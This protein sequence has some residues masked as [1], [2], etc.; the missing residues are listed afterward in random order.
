MVLGTVGE[1]KITDWTS[2]LTEITWLTKYLE[3]LQL[4]WYIMRLFYFICLY[5]KGLMWTY[6]NIAYNDIVIPHLDY[7]NY[8][9]G[10]GGTSPNLW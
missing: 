8:L 5:R 2:K 9:V 10:G 6:N 3:E 4:S 7:L 1:I